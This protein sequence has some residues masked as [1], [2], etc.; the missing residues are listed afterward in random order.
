MGLMQILTALFAIIATC[1]ANYCYVHYSAARAGYSSCGKPSTIDECLS[2]L[3]E[4]NERDVKRCYIIAGCSLDE[5][6][7]GTKFAIQHCRQLSV[8]ELKRRA[9]TGNDPDNQITTADGGSSTDA[10]SA[11][12]SSAATSSAEASSAEASSTEASSAEASSTEASSAEASSAEA[13]STEASSTEA[14]SSEAS[15][16]EE[17]SKQTLSAMSSTTEISSPSASSKVARTTVSSS[18]ISSSTKISSTLVLS[19]SNSMSGTACFT[20][21]TKDIEVCDIHTT[22]G[23]TETATCAKAKSLSSKCA[24]NRICATDAE[25][26]DICMEKRGMGIEGV[27]V[28]TV[29]GAAIVIGFFYLFFTCFRASRKK[30]V[31]VSKAQATDMSLAPLLSEGQEFTKISHLKASME[32]N[33]MQPTGYTTR[34]LRVPCTQFN[35]GYHLTRYFPDHKEDDAFQGEGVVVKQEYRPAIRHIQSN[36]TNGTKCPDPKTEENNSDESAVKWSTSTTLKAVDVNT[37][38]VLIAPPD[39]SYSPLCP[40]AQLDRQKLPCTIK[41]GMVVVKTL[42][43][44]YLCLQQLNACIEGR[45]FVEAE[46]IPSFEKSAWATREWTYQEYQ[47]S[48]RWLI[49]YSDRVYFERHPRGV[50]AEAL[51][52]V[53]GRYYW[54]EVTPLKRR[55]PCQK[56]NHPS[57][58]WSWVGWVSAVEFNVV[59]SPVHFGHRIG[60]AVV[61][62]WDADHNITTLEDVCKTAILTMEIESALL[63]HGHL[64]VE[65]MKDCQFDNGRAWHTGSVE[66]FFLERISN[67]I[68]AWKTND[69]IRHKYV[70]IAVI[71]HENGFTIGRV[72]SKSE[73]QKLGLGSQWRGNALCSDDGTTA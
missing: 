6:E 69:T 39:S 35:W 3:Q 33:V 16:T 7:D 31:I 4:L 44:R 36:P 67:S 62:L 42:G 38:R 15:S 65:D 59:E 73:I 21:S 34:G 17:T 29:F 28:S 40:Y 53:N 56:D 52:W 54:K 50:P 70:S 49:F 8:N 12:I 32:H 1:R 10:S 72:Y 2:Q 47:S 27:V 5:V 48:T 26:E 9:T 51:L 20:T 37:Y 30:K 61:W 24:A 13:S 55:L 60:S 43:E 57:P 11:D 63:Y 46:P 25:G 18:T 22:G 58:S 71:Q 45:R 66:C 23:H 14:F 19:S 41:D 68:R 64:K